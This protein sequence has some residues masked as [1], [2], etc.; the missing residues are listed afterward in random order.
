MQ[1]LVGWDDRDE[2]VDPSPVVV[3]GCD[4]LVTQRAAQAVLD[5]DPD[6]PH[7]LDAETRWPGSGQAPRWGP[8]AGRGRRGCNRCKRGQSATGRSH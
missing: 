4:D 3:L 8:A 7:R 6:A 1:A 5:A 2:L